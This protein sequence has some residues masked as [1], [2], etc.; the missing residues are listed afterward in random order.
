MDQKIPAISPFPAN[1][2]SENASDHH[3]HR[4]SSRRGR[5]PAAR[6]HHSTPTTS[7]SSARSARSWARPGR[8]S[9]T[10]RRAIAK[11]ATL[12]H[13]TQ[14]YFG[15]NPRRRRGGK[16]EDVA[17]A[18][19]LFADFDGGT[20]V[21]QAR[22]RW[23]EACIPEPTVIVITG[24]GVHAWWRLQEPMEDLA[25]WTQHQ[26]ALARRLGS[27]QSV[28]DAPRIMRLPGFVNWKYAHQPLCVVES[29]DPD[30]AYSLDE[31]PDPTQFVEPA[32][33]PVE[34]EPIAAGTLSDLSRR[35]LGERLPDP[36]AWPAGHHLHRGMRHAGAP[37]APG[38][39]RGCDPEPR[40]VA[41]P[42]RR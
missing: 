29:C 37:V 22:I 34:P 2:P 40:P 9:E 11:L 21:E 25:L 18:R 38:R 41:G 17:I 31:F 6:I 4:S 1:A 14:V 36:R 30:N 33:A 24:G 19:C 13:G 39:R 20:T 26:K 8:S 28:T 10:P 12:G 16:A 35:F 27:D 42:D 32:A 3:R 15:A 7:S 23:A 5:V